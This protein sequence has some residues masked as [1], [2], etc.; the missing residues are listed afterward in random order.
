MTKNAHKTIIIAEAGI[1]H[2]GSLERAIK[3][4]AI[5]KNCGADYIKFQTAVPHLVVKQ[6]TKKPHASLAYYN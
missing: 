1:N 2:N 3:M 6:N 4:I 5:A